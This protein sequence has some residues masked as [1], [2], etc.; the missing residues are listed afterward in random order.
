MKLIIEDILQSID[1]SFKNKSIKDIYMTYIMI[2]GIIF[3][4]SYLLFWDKAQQDYLK[5][6][7]DIKNIS[8]K[9]NTDKRYLTINPK[10]KI[11][12][13]IVQCFFG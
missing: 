9:L 8:Q 13:V 3:T 4:F 1:E 11:L 12:P 7:R 6:N 5:A 10:S 2:F